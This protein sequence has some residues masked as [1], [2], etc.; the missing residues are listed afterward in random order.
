MVAWDDYQEEV[1]SIFRKLG[2]E[3]VTNVPLKGVRTS[4]DI[5][6]VVKSEHVGFNML[7]VVECKHW[8]KPVSKLHVLA[9]RE[10]VSDVGADRGLLMAENGFQSGAHEAAELTTVKLTS[11]VEVKDSA[12]YSLGMANLRVLQERT[13][14][15][16]TRYWD[17]D[18]QVRIKYGLRPEVGITGYSGRIIIDIVTEALNAA[19][20]G[21][22]PPVYNELFVKIYGDICVSADSP[23]ELHEKLTPIVIELE[24]L[25]DRAYDSIAQ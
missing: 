23:M 6:V 3:A 22:F 15:C 11:L 25:L 24:E 10:I 9:L 4:H 20:R 8:N 13:D 5:D 1:A 16:R 21:N 19:F 2:L 12:G 7:W 14:R 17:L 18:K